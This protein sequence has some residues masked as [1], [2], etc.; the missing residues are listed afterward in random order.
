MRN[1]LKIKNFVLDILFPPL[2]LSCQNILSKKSDRTICSQCLEKI[3]LNTTLFCPVCKL[4]LADNKKVCHK[5]S[6]YLLAAATNY[7]NEVTRNLIR[8]FKY[9][10]WSKLQKPLGEILLQYLGPLNLP[11]EN[12]IIIPI[13]LF[14]DRE[15]ERGF[16]QAM[17]LSQKIA[18]HYQLNLINSVLKRIKNTKT[19]ADLKDLEERKQNVENCFTV[20]NPELIKGKN[21]ILIDDVYTSGATMNEAAQTLRLAGARKIIALVVARA[22]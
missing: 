20:K 18:D 4:R 6:K 17:L 2:C 16:N 19:Q 7:D 8:F 21:I 13:P 3:L 9:R 15:K 5:D 10:K 11:I 12:F 1:L 22:R 14:K